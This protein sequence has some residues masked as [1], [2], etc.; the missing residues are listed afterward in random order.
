[1]EAPIAPADVQNAT[2]RLTPSPVFSPIQE[3]IFGRAKLGFLRH[4]CNGRRPY[5]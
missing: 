5:M 2:R 1:M 3:N 4:V